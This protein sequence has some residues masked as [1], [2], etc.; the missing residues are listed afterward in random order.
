MLCLYRAGL[1]PPGGSRRCSILPKGA[2]V[3]KREYGNL[4]GNGRKIRAERE[5]SQGRGEA[6]FILTLDG[7]EAIRLVE[8]VRSEDLAPATRGERESGS[9]V[10]TLVG[11]QGQKAPQK[12]PIFIYNDQSGEI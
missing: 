12:T 6:P 9:S 2:G 11:V 1:C 10:G 4:R 3:V 8:G 5:R 7:E